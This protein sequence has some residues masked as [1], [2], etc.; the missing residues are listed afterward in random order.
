MVVE[1]LLTQLRQQWALSG[2][3]YRRLVSD[4]A[5]GKDVGSEK[6]EA[7]LQL[8]GK[9]PDNLEADVAKE[10]R[11]LELINRALASQSLS[12]EVAKLHSELERLKEEYRLKKE[13][14]E[15][16][17]HDAHRRL[18]QVSDSVTESRKAFEELFALFP[19]LNGRRR[20]LEVERDTLQNERR[21]LA[22]RIDTLKAWN[23]AKAGEFR[24]GILE[25]SEQ[26][27]REYINRNLEEIAQGE[28]RI[29]EI[30]SRLKAID[31]ELQD[32]TKR[33]L[34]RKA[35]SV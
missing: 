27:L 1:T 18:R 30:D 2:E 10:R 34:D 25:I 16:R 3:H 22:D 33:V 15:R 20:E 12:K 17:I 6:V 28:K 26:A 35:V 4:L 19:E 31:T 29:R 23:E 13:E 9:T 32:M 11:R 24:A 5:Q 14:Y 21:T 7:L 8:T